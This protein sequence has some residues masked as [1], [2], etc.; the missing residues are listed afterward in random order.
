MS[1]ISPAFERLFLEFADSEGQFVDLAWDTPSGAWVAEL[2]CG[3][4]VTIESGTAEGAIL[5][6]A[7]LGRPSAANQQ[8]VWGA[9]LL[10]SSLRHDNGGSSMALSSIDDECEC[11][12]L[13]E[14][15]ADEC[16][17]VESFRDGFARFAE[18]AR[19]W[20]QVVANGVPGG[21]C[22]AGAIR[23]ALM[24]VRA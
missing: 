2:S 24:G 9:M 1:P 12:L 19:C 11:Q 4:L 13:R 20:R 15:V 5:L 16:A 17:D 7:D 3:L 23:A 21:D 10:Y 14:L 8:E 18:D 6:C 22:T